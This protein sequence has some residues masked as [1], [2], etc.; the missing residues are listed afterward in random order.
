MC[1]KYDEKHLW[2]FSIITGPGNIIM[3][4][5]CSYCIQRSKKLSKYFLCKCL[6]LMLLPMWW[7]HLLCACVLKKVSKRCSNHMYFLISYYVIANYQL[8]KNIIE[9]HKKTTSLAHFWNIEFIREVKHTQALQNFGMRQ[10]C[11]QQQD[12]L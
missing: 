5:W 4:K 6:H 12:L 7:V 11:D 8:N 2:V 10:N 1:A 3:G 9:I